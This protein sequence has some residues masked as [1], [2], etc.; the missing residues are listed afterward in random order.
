MIIHNVMNPSIWY[1]NIY[2]SLP[3]NVVKHLIGKNGSNFTRLSEKLELKYIWYNCDTNAITMYGDKQRL[4]AAKE[5][6]CEV[7]DAIVRRV[8]PD[9]ISSVYN[10]N[11]IEDTVTLISL[12]NLIHKDDCK[13]LIGV[14]GKNFKQITRDANIYFMW[15]DDT[16][17]SIHI[18]G[19]TRHT[20][21]AIQKVHEQLSYVKEV[22]ERN[23]VQDH[24]QYQDLER[25]APNAKRQK[26][27]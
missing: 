13:H 21:K 26:I 24:G 15:Y 17:H 16:E 14:N 25:Y 6:M 27:I 18:H 19:T 8:A 1:A 5:H 11:L 4:E 22:I 20:L 23:L 12:E 3:Q 10:T 7:I 2:L 9:L